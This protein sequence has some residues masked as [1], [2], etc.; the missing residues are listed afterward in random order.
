M[1]IAGTLNVSSVYANRAGTVGFAGRTAG[2][3]GWL[4]I[5]DH[6]GG[7]QTRYVH[8]QANSIPAGIV[9]GSQVA[10]GQQIGIL[11]N[12]GN[13]GG[14]PPHVHFGV[15]TNAGTVDPEIYLNNPC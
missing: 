5:I 6:A 1:D 2:D 4:V 15:R 8:L 3:G 14:T 7:V 12:T 11:G 13:A 9:S 10:E